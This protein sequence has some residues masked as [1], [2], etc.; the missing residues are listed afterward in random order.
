MVKLV[1]RL[2]L[3]ST[4][5][6]AISASLSSCKKETEEPESEK[7]IV[8]TGAQKLQSKMWRSYKV[9]SGG[10]EVPA[11]VSSVSYIFLPNGTYQSISLLGSQDGIWQLNN[12]VLTLDGIDWDILELTKTSLKIELAPAITIFFQ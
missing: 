10:F 9:F 6:I 11:T 3:I 8:L 1:Y 7:V 5:V 4:L 12:D 2:F